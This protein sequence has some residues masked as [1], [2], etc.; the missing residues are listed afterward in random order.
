MTRRS[1][2]LS[3]GCRDRVRLGGCAA[4]APLLVVPN[5]SIGRTSRCGRLTAAGAGGIT[6]CDAGGG[7]GVTVG[8]AA[9]TEAD[10]AAGGIDESTTGPCCS[11]SPEK[12]KSSPRASSISSLYSLSS[13]S[14]V[15]AFF[16][17]VRSSIAAAPMQ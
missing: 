15:G 8:A 9:G 3:V 5:L 2:G 10:A 7:A 13:P 11:P 12:T 17:S 14:A 6:G 4:G 16:S 1:F